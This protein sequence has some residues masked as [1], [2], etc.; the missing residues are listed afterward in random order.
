MGAAA[1]GG[2]A[3]SAGLA[4]GVEGASAEVSELLEVAVYVLEFLLIFLEGGVDEAF[5]F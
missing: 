1:G 5:H 4:L 3:G 2:V